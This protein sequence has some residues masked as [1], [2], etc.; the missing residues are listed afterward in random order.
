MT[1]RTKPALPDQRNTTV[2]MGSHRSETS[3][4]STGTS[5]VDLFS[6]TVR[7]WQLVKS[8]SIASAVITDCMARKGAG[9][10]VGDSKRVSVSLRVDG[11]QMAVLCIRG[12]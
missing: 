8:N 2:G 1:K 9:D 6:T 4:P 10:R 5:K 11:S 3:L 7:R 12:C